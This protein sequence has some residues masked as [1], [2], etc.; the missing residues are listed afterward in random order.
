MKSKIPLITLLFSLLIISLGLGVSYLYGVWFGYPRGND[1]LF[2]LFKCQYILQY[3]PNQHWWSIWAGGMPLFLYYPPLPYLVLVGL[4]LIS[5]LSFEIL[6]SAL[7]V[8]AVGL[9]AVGI[10]LIVFR[11]TK[12]VIFSFLPAFFYLSTPSSWDSAF[13]AGVYMRATAIPFF[14][15]SLYF[16]L[17]FWQEWENGNFNSR[18]WSLTSLCLGFTL[19]IHQHVALV[20]FGTLFLFSFFFVKGKLLAKTA[21]LGKIILAAILVSAS[22]W[23]PLLRFFPKNNPTT[24]WVSQYAKLPVYWQDIIPFPR[25]FSEIIFPTANYERFPRLTPFLLPLGLILAF[26]VAS[27]KPEI[28]KKDSFLIRAL[29]FFS[30]MTLFW[31]SYSSG[32]FT[33]FAKIF[34]LINMA[35]SFMGTLGALWYLPIFAT[36]AIG[37]FFSFLL[38]N[39]LAVVFVFCFLLAASCLFLKE[40]YQGL[41]YLRQLSGKP[42]PFKPANF[43][44][45]GPSF[46][47]QIL[48][49]ITE[50]SRVA[51]ASPTQTALAFSFLFPKVS[52]TSHYFS[53]GVANFDLYYYLES[54]LFKGSQNENEVSFLFNWWG[55]DRVFA[56][57]EVLITRS[58]NL[59][60]LAGG[61]GFGFYSY[62]RPSSLISPTNTPTILFIG[63]R[64]T[65]NNT[66]FRSLALG[67]YNSGLLI[68]IIGQETVEKNQLPGL[69][70]FPRLFLYDY[71]VNSFS[72]AA[73]ILVDYV[74]EGGT[75]VIESN[76]VLETLRDLPDPFPIKRIEV[77]EKNNDWAFGLASENPYISAED[78]N[79]FSPAKEGDSPWKVSEAR[80][81]KDWAKTLLTSQGKPIL[82]EGTLGKGKVIWSGLNLPYHVISSKNEKEAE[83]LA[84]ILGA[85]HSPTKKPDFTTKFDNPQDRILSL[86]EKARGVLLKENYFPNWHSSAQTDKKKIKLKIYEAGPGFMFAF[87]PKDTKEVV[88]SYR[89]SWLEKG[90][91]IVSVVSFLWLTIIVLLPKLSFKFQRKEPLQQP[92]LE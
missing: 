33:H 36:L 66:F 12:N 35:Y 60:P 34:P 51:L 76:S 62:D 41:L 48:D 68:P 20:A 45:L 61:D 5:G 23:L 38:K 29:K 46:R 59:K 14:I 73:K 81:L 84:K 3:F 27:T 83:I 30:L 90:A 13:S 53:P 2:H 11:L 37:I 50:N 55:I 31:F 58:T 7:G 91:D 49:N 26:I 25:L 42:F 63:S 16:S 57:P 67:N 69:T 8:L 64:K 1:A 17:C 39:K 21:A 10:Y 43:S 74:K 28:F 80:G 18:L 92:R 70:N 82:V 79:N 77:V 87:L 40:Q 24:S 15:F 19:L 52:Q 85:S 89:R 65:Y 88:F 22:F 78:L 54:L 72:S 47:Q 32:L 86:S 9:G 56:S 6:L 4:K 75:L 44:F 71:K